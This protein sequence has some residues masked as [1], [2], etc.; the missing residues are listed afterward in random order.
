MGRYNS[1]ALIAGMGAALT[2]SQEDNDLNININADHEGD[3]EGGDAGVADFDNSAP[4]DTAAAEPAPEV[5][6]DE[7]IGDDT[8][9]SP[10]T[11]EL[12][13]AEAGGEVDEVAT[14]IEDVNDT[15]AGLEGIVIQLATISQ[16]GI[17]VTPFIAE[18]IRQQ[19][20]FVTRKF[21][22]LRVDAEGQEIVASTESWT[23]SQEATTDGIMDKA[24]GKLKNAG[25]AVVKFLKDLWE[26]IKA[27]FGSVTSSASIMRNKANS[28]K[29]RSA[30][31]QKSITLPGTLTSAPFNAA[32]IN[33]LTA[34]IKSVAGAKIDAGKLVEQGWSA[35]NATATMA[36][37]K[38]KGTYL[39]N[40]TVDVVDNVPVVK[41]AE[42]TKSK[43]VNLRGSE[44]AGIATA[45]VGLAD[46]IEAYKREESLRKVVND[47]LLQI[48]QEEVKPEDAS[49]YARWR[50]ARETSSKWGKFVAFEGKLIQK[51]IAV[52]NAANNALAA[53][54]AKPAK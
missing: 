54:T 26:K 30:D 25:A 41:S 33:K 22:K 35:Y 51:A 12:D 10:E 8:S 3:G 28:L 45:V 24:V 39:G 15:A 11:A 37:H 43:N 18:S 7:N 5:V 48:L 52:G 29:G 53:G 36:Q 9:G 46:A 21:P 49:K 1:A 42:A 19:Y 2:V 32:E 27:L 6:V 38:N 17:E 4:V 16:E 40:F 23:V 20:N 14:Q 44:V 47:K 13:V 34:L 31:P 50:K